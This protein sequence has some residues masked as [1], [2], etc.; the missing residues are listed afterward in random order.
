MARN[1]DTFQIKDTTLG[2]TLAETR[3]RF[4]CFQRS[5][6]GEPSPCF[7]LE[8][9]KIKNYISITLD[10]CVVGM[11]GF[12]PAASWS[13]TKRAAELRYIPILFFRRK[14]YFT[15]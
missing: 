11:T 12:E 15:T 5:R 9:K 6:T 3:G 10:A 1:V 8:H 2:N 7:F 4:S 14:K 13:Q